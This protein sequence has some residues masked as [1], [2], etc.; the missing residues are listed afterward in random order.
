MLATAFPR[1]FSSADWWFDLKWDG[2]R[3]LLYVDGERVQLRS[4]RGNDLAPR[5]PEL[6]SIRAS[7]PVVIDGEIVAMGDDGKPSFFLLGYR[8]SQLVVFDILH[9]QRALT[10]LPLEERW[11]QLDEIDL[12]GPVT[13]SQPTREDGEELFEVVKANGLEG[14]VAKKS[15]SRYFPGRRSADWRKVVARLQLNAVVGG[16]LRGTRGGFGS[17]LLGLYEGDRLL[18]AGSA[19]SGLDNRSIN[20]LWPVLQALERPTSPFAEKAA[21]MGEP[22][23]IEPQLVARIEYREW[24]PDRRLRAPVFK[25]IVQDLDPLEVTFETEVATNRLGP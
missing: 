7:E 21:F 15:G 20:E 2:F 16:Y 8:P 10:N 1:A 5:F 14:V 3:C 19:G 25:G 22:V 18:V 6:R 13:R 17:L 9:R 11:Q 24:T 23:W 12:Q 4:R